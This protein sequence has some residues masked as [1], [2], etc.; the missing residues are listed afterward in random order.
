MTRS[1]AISES[2]DARRSSA[3]DVVSAAAEAIRTCPGYRLLQTSPSSLQAL[4]RARRS[5]WSLTRQ[6]E[7]LLLEIAPRAGRVVIDVSGTGS[8]E[9]VARLRALG[10]APAAGSGPS[11]PPAAVAPG[12]PGRVAASQPAPPPPEAQAATVLR[13]DLPFA[14]PASRIEVRLPDGR[15]EPIDCRL[16]VGRDPARSATVGPQ[17]RLVI[18][19]ATVSKTHCEI[20]TEAGTVYVLDCHSTNGTS[21]A[22]IGGPPTPVEPGRATAVTVGATVLIGAVGVGIAERR[23]PA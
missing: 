21:C 10:A 5:F 20:W 19:D 9:L 12:S 7:T 18:D 3:S 2:I 14:P 11:G 1:V 15:V 17:R 22:A 8:P 6:T 4:R 13:A 16:V 23:D